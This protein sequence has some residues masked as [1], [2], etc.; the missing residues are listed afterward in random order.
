[1]ST[2]LTELDEGGELITSVDD[3]GTLLDQSGDGKYA[4]EKALAEVTKVGDWL[5]FIQLMGSNSTEV[6]Q[7]KFPMGHF[8]LRSGRQLVDLGTSFVGVF[9]DWRPKAMK[10]DSKPISVFDTEHPK[11]KEF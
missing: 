10:F 7:G 2:D 8:C 6:K 3:L 1:M 9:L 4:N 5:P 11:F